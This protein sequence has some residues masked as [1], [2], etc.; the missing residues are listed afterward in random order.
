MLNITML[1]L[2]VLIYLNDFLDLS[3]L[4]S[5]RL[6]NKLFKKTVDRAYPTYVRLYQRL[7]RMAPF[8]PA[9][10]PRENFLKKYNDALRAVNELHRQEFESLDHSLLD[11]LECGAPI[12][13]MINLPY[14]LSYLERLVSQ[15]EIMELYNA[16][17]IEKYIDPNS[18]IL[19]V[20]LIHEPITRFP[21]NL[22]T[23]PKYVDYFKKLTAIDISNNHVYFIPSEIEKCQALEYLYCEYSHVSKLPATLGNCPELTKVDCKY[24]ELNSL[25]ESLADCQFLETVDCKGNHLTELPQRLVDKLGKEWEKEMLLNQ[26]IPIPSKAPSLQ[27]HQ[28]TP[29]HN[30]KRQMD[31]DSEDENTPQSAHDVKRKKL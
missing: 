12:I 4:K 10:L 13:A 29:V 3:G 14:K 31:Y 18:T 26:I 9:E 21:N 22:F 16:S 17:I 24:G 25:P 6:V 11:G 27:A 19:D 28:Y 23:M 30:I 8:L 7:H 5:L 1:P 15:H 20:S 2:D